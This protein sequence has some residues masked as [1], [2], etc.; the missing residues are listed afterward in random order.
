MRNKLSRLALAVV[1]VMAL[2]LGLFG[3]MQAAHASGSPVVVQSN[4]VHEYV[5]ANAPSIQATFSSSVTSGN[6]LVALVAWGGGND[7]SVSSVTDSQSNTYTQ[8]A[9]KT[10]DN[11][12]DSGEIWGTTASSSGSVTISVT[13]TENGCPCGGSGQ[14]STWLQSAL[15]IVEVS[16]QSSLSD[17]GGPA[18][19]LDN[20]GG[21]PG[22]HENHIVDTS[23]MSATDTIYVGLFVDGGANAS[24]QLLASGM[25]DL[26]HA[27]STAN[28]E[29]DFA[30][31]ATAGSDW[32]VDTNPD[33]RYATSLVIGING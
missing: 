13:L 26:G 10:S 4:S 19:F 25:T 31:Q 11:I 20:G 27:C 2:G 33:A 1:A 12:L 30:Y 16:G 17:S 5:A 21:A 28:I 18:F 22:S 9:S 23:G 6:E 3:G 14:P 8:L 32:E 29:Y 24:C 15:G 7:W